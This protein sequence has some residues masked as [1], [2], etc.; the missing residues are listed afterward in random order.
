MQRS[1]WKGTLRLAL[2]A[3]QTS[4]NSIKYARYIKR[5]IPAKPMMAHAT[6]VGHDLS[7]DQ[8]RQTVVRAARTIESHHEPKMCFDLELAGR[9][10]LR[11]EEEQL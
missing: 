1:L 4:S 5:L 3:D 6:G 8:T 9:T 10:A 7:S 11:A 2:K